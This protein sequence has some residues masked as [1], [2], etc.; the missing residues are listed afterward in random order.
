M[1]KILFAGI[2]LALL[3]F[4]FISK[5]DRTITGTI[6]DDQSNPVPFATI[7]A[8]GTRNAVAANSTGNFKI[9]VSDKT[10]ILE[11]TAV[12]FQTEEVQITNATNYN[13][14]MN[15]TTSSINDVVVTTALGIQRKSIVSGYSTIQG[16]VSGLSISQNGNYAY[17]PMIEKDKEDKFDDAWRY[18]D[19]FNTEGY[20]HIVENPFLKTNDNPLSTFS[21]DVDA[22]SYAMFVAL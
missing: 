7:T 11:I 9:Q 1:K 17:A 3:S 10:K 18:N 15:R 19:S 4:A 22:A 21:I 13:I 20:D 6:K 12:G 8:K 2:L 16:K 14:V 5:A